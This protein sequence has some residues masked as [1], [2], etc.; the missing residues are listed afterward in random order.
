[1]PPAGE[2]EDVFSR[3]NSLSAEIPVGAE[4]LCFIP[5]FGGE[6]CPHYRP[7]AKGALYGLTFS[8]TRAHLVRALME[9]L[10]YN[11]YSVYRMLVPDS[12]PDLVVTGGILKSP[13]WLQI[14]ADFFGKTLWLPAYRKPLR[15]VACS[16]ACGRSA[17]SGASRSLPLSSIL[18]GSGIPPRHA[19]RS[20]GISSTHTSNC[21]QTFMVQIGDRSHRRH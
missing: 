2:G 8:H 16:S 11:L 17:Q 9:G 20:T 15:G 13:T 6:R 1:M 10:A 3:M 14:V 7:Q 18:R 4:G 12:E 21:M 19:A 5:L